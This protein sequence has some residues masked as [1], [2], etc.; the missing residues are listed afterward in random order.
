MSALETSQ[1]KLRQ[2]LAS[3]DR[4]ALAAASDMEAHDPEVAAAEQPARVLEASRRP[5]SLR[6]QAARAFPSRSQ[7]TT[8]DWIGAPPT[9]RS[10]PRTYRDVIAPPLSAYVSRP[11]DSMFMDVCLDDFS[12]HVQHG[13]PKDVRT[14][15]HRTAKA[16]RDTFVP[17]PAATLRLVFTHIATA[18]ASLELTAAAHALVAT[19][20]Q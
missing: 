15:V 13:F 3:M 7:S 20:R 2:Q 18:P 4:E 1:A 19:L 12:D 5:P 17:Y 6:P 16:L 14:H 9:P 10:S 8:P 11:V